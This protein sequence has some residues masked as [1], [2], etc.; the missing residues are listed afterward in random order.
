[1]QS[2]DSPKSRALQSRVHYAIRMNVMWGQG[3]NVKGKSIEFDRAG[4]KIFSLFGGRSHDLSTTKPYNKQ[5]SF[6]SPLRIRT[7]VDDRNPGTGGETIGTERNAQHS[8][9]LSHGVD[10]DVVL[11]FGLVGTEWL[12]QE[13]PQVTLHRFDL[14]FPTGPLLDPGLRLRPLLVQRE[15]TSL[16]TPLDQ[17]VGLRYEPGTGFEQ[18]WVHLF[19]AV[20]DSSGRSIRGEGDG[21]E[22]R[23]SIVRWGREGRGSDHGGPSQV[24]GEDGLSIGLVDR[25]GSHWSELGFVME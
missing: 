22:L 17:L 2:I 3:K 14:N 19:G 20:E 13:R 12:D 9:H 24:V 4:V 18:P 16:A 7:A 6:G 23:G 1:M 8:T 5:I 25:F 11:L 15:Q 10:V 21:R